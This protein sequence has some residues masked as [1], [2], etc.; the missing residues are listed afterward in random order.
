[1]NPPNEITIEVFQRSDG[2]YEYNIYNAA[3][4]EIT[5]DGREPIDGGVCTSDIQTAIQMASSHASELIQKHTQDPQHELRVI[6]GG[7]ST[8]RNNITR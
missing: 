2:D 1:M 5:Y 3:L 8:S 4:C 7:K 6:R